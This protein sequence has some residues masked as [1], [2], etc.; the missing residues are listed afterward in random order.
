MIDPKYDIAIIRRWMLLLFASIGLVYFV[1]ISLHPNQIT[2]VLS[3][4]WQLLSP[5][6]TQENSDP[7]Q[8]SDI[9]IIWNNNN[10]T[11]NQWSWTQE[12]NIEAIVEDL[13]IWWSKD[14][15]NPDDDILVSKKVA[16]TKDMIKD[17]SG[18]K[19]QNIQH[20]IMQEIWIR[21][22]YALKDEDNTYFF[23]LWSVFYDFKSILSELWWD[24]VEI[25]NQKDIVENW[26]YADRIT[27]FKIPKYKNKTMIFVL[28]EWIDKWLFIVPHNIYFKKKK[29]I[30]Q[31]FESIYWDK[32][33]NI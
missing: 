16:F 6:S 2:S 28:Q 30:Q 7:S 25:T 32:T 31:Q 20:P 19:L 26:L 14:I 29:I 17:F 23:F 4:A 9:D 10:L 24:V 13:S 33:N 5:S 15:E 11:W 21:Y 8:I 1:Y 3:Y 18:M 27:Y 12:K 22:Q